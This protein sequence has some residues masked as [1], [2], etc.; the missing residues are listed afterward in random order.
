MGGTRAAPSD[1]DAYTTSTTAGKSTHAIYT[2]KSIDDTLDPKNISIRESRDLPAYP[3]SNALIIALDVTGSMNKVSDYMIRTGLVTLFTEIYNR[4]PVIDPHILFCAVG[5]V[6]AGDRAPLQATQF[7]CD[8]VLVDQLT[9]IWLE[10]G[11]GG[12]SSE[13]Y[14]LP[15]Y[16]AA[17]KTSIDC[18]D[19]RGKKGYLFTIGDDGPPSSL[20]KQELER[21]FGPGEYQDMSSEQLYTLVS[22]MYNVYHIL[23]EQGSSHSS[24]HVDRWVDL[25]GERAIRLSDYTKL[26]ETIIS[27]IQVNEGIDASVVTKSWSGDTSLVVS[28]ALKGITKGA[29][30]DKAVVE[31]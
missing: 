26:S 23:V 1:W 4:K 16:F 3:N 25:I 30:L 17:N 12:N 27:L 15:W 9:K 18:F 29:A 2:S 21:V 6:A 22:R 7:E 24:H 14:T 20:S 11:G 19:K 5:D 28:N 10:N 8:I 13:S 31:F